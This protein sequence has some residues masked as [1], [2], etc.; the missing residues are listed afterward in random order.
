MVGLER[1]TVEL[2]PHRDEWREAFETE[3][4]RLRSTLGDRLLAVEHVG[5]TAVEGLAAKPVIDV[6]AVVEESGDEEGWTRR[7][8]PLGYEFRPDD[9][10]PDR[11]F[12]A[13]G[14]ESDRTHYLSVT[15]RGS[16]T[17][18][19]QLRFR[20]YLRDNPD[21]VAEYERLKRDLAEAYPDDRESYTSEKSA[22]V[23][24]ILRRANEEKGR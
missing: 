24:E 2:V 5:S 9:G 23:E 17:H 8:E 3:A 18:V 19:E 13:K 15:E 6:L 1:G 20:D 7:L 22:F 12:Y 14:P 11:L 21:V 16:E 4:E 10:V